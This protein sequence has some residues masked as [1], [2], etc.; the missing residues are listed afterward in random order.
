MKP[1]KRIAVIDVGSNTI[2]FVI[3][4]VSDRKIEKV[5]NER[6]VTRLG[7]ELE[8][9]KV[10]NKESIEKSLKF[11]EKFK[12]IGESLKVDKLIAIGTSALRD[13]KD[14][15]MFCN[16]VRQKIGID[17]K[18]ISGDEEAYFTIEGIRAGIES[19]I[20]PL[21]AVDIGGGSIE[22]VYENGYV[23]KGSINFGVVKAYEKYFHSALDL[24]KA[25]QNLKEFFSEEIKS[26]I[27]RKT[28][29]SF[30]ATGGTSV[31]IAMIELRLTEYKP[32]AIHG[33]LIS[34]EK[35]KEMINKI[36]V[37]NLENW[38]NSVYIPKDRFDIL[39]PGMIILETLADYLETKS[40][41]I[42]DYGI[43]E[44]IM[45]NHERFCYNNKL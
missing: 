36:I 26:S 24:K 34:I 44:G 8:K 22:W 35:L 39:L 29:K 32:N 9:N 10:L 37:T 12:A 14:G 38:E 13:A 33:T 19:P 43:I 27:P 25:S 42:S 18:I 30:I 20:P 1:I 6:V 2:R 40:I 15:E 28:V 7:K 11:L 41:M 21:L 23:D 3:A 17:L 4:D 45:I 31:T 16:F 5:H